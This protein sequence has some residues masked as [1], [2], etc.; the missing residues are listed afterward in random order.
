MLG[1]LARFLR[2]FGYDTIYTNDL[3]DYFKID[4][5]PDD[6]LIEYAKKNDRIIITKDLPLYKSFMENSIY[7][8]GEGIYNYLHHLNKEF[9][10]EFKFN[11]KRA[12]CSICNSELKRVEHKSSIKDD[13]LKETYKNYNDF[14]QCSNLLCKKVYWQGSHIEDIEYKLGKSLKFD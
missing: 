8:R 13:I 2:I 10:L 6:K 3:I 7:L 1:K 11:F 12:R 14:Y 9:G 5:V 4:P